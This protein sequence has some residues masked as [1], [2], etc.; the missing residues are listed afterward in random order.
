MSTEI[1]RCWFL[2]S[3]CTCRF[4]HV[5]FLIEM[6]DCADGSSRTSERVYDGRCYCMIHT[7]SRICSFFKISEMRKILRQYSIQAKIFRWCLGF[8][9]LFIF[10]FL[11]PYILLIVWNPYISGSRS[12]NVVFLW[13]LLLV[14]G[15]YRGCLRATIPLQIVVLVPVSPLVPLWRYFS[16]L[17]LVLID[18]I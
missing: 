16:E 11:N 10:Q 7:T 8:C 3:S 9:F 6:A 2:Q 17:I 13:Y 14:H 4:F 5:G 15:L 18:L 12:A 1:W